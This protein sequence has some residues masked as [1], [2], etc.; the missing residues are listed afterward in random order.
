MNFKVLTKKSLSKVKRKKS[1]LIFL[2]NVKMQK[3]IMSSF[4]KFFDQSA[5]NL[6][7]N[8]SIC[9]SV[10]TNVRIKKILAKKLIL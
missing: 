8:N 7:D 10:K 3:I 4:K 2:Y 9:L 5:G 6:H 1:S